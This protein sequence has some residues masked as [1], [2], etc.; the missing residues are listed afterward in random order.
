MDNVE[1]TH[2]IDYAKGQQT[3]SQHDEER[4]AEEKTA[5]GVAY[6]Y[7]QWRIVRDGCSGGSCA[8]SLVLFSRIVVW[9]EFLRHCG[10]STMSG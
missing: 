4:W 2:S 1:R 5:R 3:D 10:A 9:K 6:P 7:E 8:A